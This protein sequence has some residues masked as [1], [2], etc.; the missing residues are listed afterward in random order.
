MI[1]ADIEPLILDEAGGSSEF[2][3]DGSNNASDEIA[4]L[5]E[6]ADLP[7]EM[8]RA[9]Y[10]QAAQS[11]P[12]PSVTNQLRSDTKNDAE[13]ASILSAPSP[14]A[15]Q[16]T[17]KEG[18]TTPSLRSSY[19]RSSSA[20]SM[21]SGRSLN[22]SPSLEGA[23]GLQ[24]IF[25]NNN[26]DNDADYEPVLKKRKRK[27]IRIGD[28]YQ[29]DIPM[30]VSDQVPATETDYFEM[31]PRTPPGL[32]QPICHKLPNSNPN[33]HWKSNGHTAFQPV[34]NNN[35]NQLQKPQQINKSP[36]SDSSN[37]LKASQASTSTSI[38]SLSP[39]QS[40][41]PS[42][43]CSSSSSSSASSVHSFNS[44]AIPTT[45]TVVPIPTHL[46]TTHK[47]P[48]HTPNRP[49]LETCQ[50]KPHTI[51]QGE[52]LDDFLKT[53]WKRWKYGAAD[54]TNQ[55]KTLTAGSEELPIP[56]SELLL[57]WLYESDY[58]VSKSIDYVH[59]YESKTN[60]AQQKY[61]FDANT[62][63]ARRYRFVWDGD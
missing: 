62:V 34:K 55:G 21:E 47:V 49:P 16:T 51:V 52:I 17:T 13:L 61:F 59:K 41:L 20:V 50:W 48:T 42:T 7:I 28:G 23:G 60:N 19:L 2:G 31:P 4:A 46:Q 58:D 24:S 30:Q 37:Y 26:S 15:V 32:P 45:A 25:D 53:C 10:Q 39:H 36:Q 57:K 18:R 9:R 11:M 29:A 14:G 35:R 33:S 40:R 6:D 5:N 22:S 54:T 27:E 38:A 44:S 1:D 8:L 43:S 12:A 3:S 56:D 63:G